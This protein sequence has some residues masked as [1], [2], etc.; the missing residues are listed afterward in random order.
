[1]PYAPNAGSGY[2][3]EPT[4]DY[5][6]VSDGAS[7]TIY[8]YM[9]NLLGTLGSETGITIAGPQWI[10]GG[11]YYLETSPNPSLR[12]IIPQKIPGYSQ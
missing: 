9:G 2:T 6:A 4:G 1:M 3:W 7:I 8:D 10:E 5:V 12:I 11:I